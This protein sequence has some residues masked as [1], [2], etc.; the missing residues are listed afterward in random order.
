MDAGEIM[1]L[2]R[3]ENVYTTGAPPC[4]GIGLKWSGEEY[5]TALQGPVA[6]VLFDDVGKGEAEEMLSG[7]TDTHF[8]Q[9]RLDRIFTDS[10]YPKP[11]QAGEAIAEA[12]L[13]AHRNCYFPWSVKRDMRKQGSSLPGADLVGLHVDAH[14]NCIAFGE[15]KTSSEE[16]Y[17]PRVVYGDEGL[18]KQLKD[19]RDNTAV[20]NDLF[21]YLAH[22]AVRADWKER[23]QEAAKRYLANQS[24]VRMFGFLVRDVSPNEMDLKGTVRDIGRNCPGSMVIEVFGLYIQGARL[25]DAGNV[26]INHRRDTTS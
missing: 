1:T 16:Q 11:W 9:A 19:I 10:R 24:D 15:V 13:V 20:R 18:R 8:D 26:L 23:F 25:S 17:P 12:W 14:G 4:I 2:A 7:F 5:S 6:A 22:R 3:G 21:R